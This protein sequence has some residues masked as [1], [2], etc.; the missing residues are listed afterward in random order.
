VTD[1]EGEVVPFLVGATAVAIGLAVTILLLSRPSRTILPLYAGMIPIGSVVKLPVPLPSPFNTLSSL[2][3]AAAII[4]LLGHIVIYRRG[5]IP[6]LPVAT[7][8]GF[9]AWM[10][11]TTFWA[12]DWRAALDL[13]FVASPLLLMMVSVGILVT[14][15]KD[16]DVM[17]LA[18]VCGGIAVGGYALVLLMSGSA[19]PI[20]GTTERFSVA[21]TAEET[22]PNQL[23]ASLLLPA[24]LAID[25]VV[26]G[27]PSWWRPTLW[28]AVG[29]AGTILS[30]VAIIMS[31]SRGGVLAAIVGFVL[32]LFLWWRRGPVE[33]RWV[34]RVVT[35][36]ACIGV[37]LV[38]VIFIST[39]FFPEGR[40]ANIVRNDSIQRLIHV[41]T[42]S[43]GRSEIWSTGFL[44][45]EKY[46]G[47][48]GGLE[49]FPIVFDQIFPFS[50]AAKNVGSDRP[51]HNVYLE[52]AVETGFVGLSLFALAL[53]MEWRLLRSTAMRMLAPSVGTAMVALLLANIFEGQIWFKYFWIVFVLLRVAEGA[54]PLVAAGGLA[55]PTSDEIRSRMGPPPTT[56]NSPSRRSRLD[57]VRLRL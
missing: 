40:V 13:I 2:L 15:Q 20:H 27:G 4:A 47:W 42:G 31:G 17:K 19:L 41:Q 33:R 23:A 54:G 46:C 32:T 1:G 7:W 48:G 16:L 22:N 35:A 10:M 39:R 37:G 9:F 3:G 28:R 44:A 53:V 36:T 49:S 6:S 14:D 25:F 21:S 18:I 30:F 11:A 24:F 45:C 51:A 5:R 52:L 34:M 56:R 8:L 12:I 43:S 55:E 50:A 38:C 57:G 29:A 26:M